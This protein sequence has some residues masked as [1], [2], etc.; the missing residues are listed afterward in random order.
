MLLVSMFDMITGKNK[1]EIGKNKNLPRRSFICLNFMHPC[2]NL[3]EKY[4]QSFI[5]TGYPNFPF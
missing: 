2:I 5:D 1:K 4:F 3:A